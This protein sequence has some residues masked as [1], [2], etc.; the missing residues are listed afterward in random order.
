MKTQIIIPMS[1]FGERFR[2]AG[3]NIPKPLIEVEN[4][5]IIAHVI[6]MFKNENNFIFICN[7]D[8]LSDKNFKMESII[9]KYCPTGKIVGIKP[10]KLG[11][12]HA[13]NSIREIIDDDIPTIVNY[14]D[15]TCY[16]SWSNFKHFVKE[17]DCDGS[18]PAYRGFHPHSLGK[19]NYAYIKEKNGWVCDIQEK[20][21]FTKNRINEFASSGTYYFKSGKLMKES[22][23][24]VMKKNI[25]VGGEFYVSL[26]YKHLINNNLKIATYPLQHFMQWGTPEDV[27]EYNNWSKTFKNILLNKYENNKAECYGYNIIAMAGLGKRFA[28]EGYKST[29]PMIEVSGKAMVIQATNDL[30]CSKSNTYVLRSDMK[31]YKNIIDNIKRND[32]N[33]SFKILEG[34]TDGQASTALIG[35]EYAEEQIGE[36]I[37]PITFGACDSGFLYNYDKYIELIND[38]NV[39]VIVWATRGNINAIR[40]PEMFGWIKENNEKIINISV[41]KSLDDPEKDPMVVGTFTFKKSKDFKDS[42]AKLKSRKGHVNGE[43]YLDSCINDSISLGLNCYILEVEDYLSWGTPNDLKTFEY[44]QSCFHKWDCHPYNLNSDP[45]VNQN[46]LDHLKEKYKEIIPDVIEPKDF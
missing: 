38:D 18:I 13:V 11:P 10:H 23:D 31:D 33:A 36:D 32:S 42:F 24:Y 25:N 14:C 12:I 35:L 19:T 34:V 17:T 4:K 6:E 46:S 29:K 37:G 16:W 7:E 2:K 30:P 44:W 45:K 43:Y 28:D 5:P 9:K 3:Y 15:F 40:R 1:G 20:E 39:D 26:A 27:N 21:P 41:K 22:F 8:H